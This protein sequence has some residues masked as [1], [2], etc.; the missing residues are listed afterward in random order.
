[1]TPITGLK[2]PVHCW[3]HLTLCFNARNCVLHGMCWM[4]DNKDNKGSKA[5]K[6]SKPSNASEASKP[7]IATKAKFF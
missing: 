3:T 6:A 2:Y 7:S 1:M 4:D 5:S